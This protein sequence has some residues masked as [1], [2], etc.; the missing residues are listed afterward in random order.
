MNK[1]KFFLLTLLLMPSF[2]VFNCSKPFNGNYGYMTTAV[3]FP[4]NSFS[5]KVIPDDTVK[6]SVEVSGVGLEEK[7]NFDLTKENN[8]KILTEVPVGKKNIEA[9]AFSVSGVILAQ[10]SSEAEIIANQNTVAE[11][12]LKTVFSIPTPSPSVSV[13]PSVIPSSDPSFIPVPDKTVEPTPSP[14]DSFNE[15]KSG[16]NGA[17]VSLDVT[18]GDGSPLPQESGMSVL[19]TSVRPIQSSGQNLDGMKQ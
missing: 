4:A 5:L 7:I 8:R 1:K 9:K 3:K 16:R 18:I 12:E 19:E 2:G 13:E 10:G 11:I 14:S 15:S 6:I 17:N